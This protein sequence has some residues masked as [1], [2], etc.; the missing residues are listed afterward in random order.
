MESNVISFA[1]LNGGSG[2]LLERPK[3]KVVQ[4]TSRKIAQASVLGGREG[5]ILRA[6]SL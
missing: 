3:E 2:C 4:A 5:L 1:K 6:S